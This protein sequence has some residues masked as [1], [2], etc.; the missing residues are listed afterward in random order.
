MPFSMTSPF[1][2]LPFQTLRFLRHN[3]LRLLFG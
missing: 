2:F 3:P 1:V